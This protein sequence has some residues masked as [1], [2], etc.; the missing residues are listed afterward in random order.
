[1]LTLE[2]QELES[3]EQYGKAEIPELVGHLADQAGRLAQ[4][5]RADLES[6]LAAYE[7]DTSQRIVVVTAGKLNG[8][9]IDAFATRAV[10][11]WQL[12]NEEHTRY[13]LIAIAP[14]DGAARIEPGAAMRA[15]MPDDTA[16]QILEEAM[17]PDFQY[18]RY[19]EG[20]QK[21]V[22][23]VMAAC[24]ELQAEPAEQ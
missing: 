8:Q 1:V 12:G 20:I 22:A 2:S 5:Q 16:R 23:R 6:Q 15:C 7:S 13:V 11:T 9:S 14:N 17:V 21:G 18:Q 3:L 24:R 4:K 10:T 19:A